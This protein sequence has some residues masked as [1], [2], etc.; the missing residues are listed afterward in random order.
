VAEICAFN[1]FARIAML[2]ANIQ[3]SSRAQ[4]AALQVT[5]VKKPI[6]EV[7]VREAIDYF[8]AL[9]QLA[10]AEVRLNVPQ[11]E[12]ITKQGNR[13]LTG[14]CPMPIKIPEFIAASAVCIRAT[15]R[16]FINLP[17]ARGCGFQASA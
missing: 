13:S 5:F 7:A 12:M 8:L 3:Q 2:T 15:A 10:G 6:T 17:K 9:S 16:F 14:A 11:V 4:A 1:P